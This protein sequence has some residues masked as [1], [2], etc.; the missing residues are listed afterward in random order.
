MA[1]P[2]TWQ[3]AE[4]FAERVGPVALL[5]GHP[6]TLKK[7]STETVRLSRAAV[8][9]KGGFGARV[10]SWV[11]YWMQAAVWVCRS[12]RQT[13]L[14]VFSTP[15]I[16]PWL[17][18][19][20]RI[21]RGQRYAVMVHDVYPDVLVRLGRFSGANPLVRAWRALNCRAYERAELVMT[22]G[23][24]MAELLREAFDP[25][26]TAHGRVEVIP[27]WADTEEIRPL[28]KAE[29]WFAQQHGQA[30]KLTVM[31]S[32]NMG[33]SHD[34][35]TMIET[36]ERLREESGIHFM[37][38]GLGPQWHVLT[39]RLRERALP[40]ATLLPWQPEEVLP[41]SLATA[42]VAFVSL[43]EELA[44]TMLPSKAFS[45]MAAGVPLVVSAG[46]EGELPEL[47]TRFGVGWKIPQGD[48]EA[49]AALLVRLREGDEL[50][51]ARSA[52]R[53]A[54]EQIGSRKN[55]HAM[56]ALLA[57]VLKRQ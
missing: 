23:P 5:T 6:D 26:Q 32:G 45:F 30:G 52:S 43:R 29:N 13:P 24:H 15:P 31:Y 9:S 20:F 47:V 19:L 27:P 38:I 3:F 28:P 36:A 46:E 51:P 10:L 34:V 53:R 18:L 50:A 42:D 39:N 49:M 37:F 25:A 21:L 4:D 41:Y 48:A 22:L 55:S 2:L 1:G 35:D 33:F 14:L 7:K 54:A 12:P 44:G 8:Q 56:A 16:L 57:S 40:N 17:A 11:V